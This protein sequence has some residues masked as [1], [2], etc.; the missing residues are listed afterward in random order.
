MNIVS[1]D[2]KK[3]KR[4]ALHIVLLGLKNNV[5][6]A[7]RSVLAKELDTSRGQL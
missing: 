5:L 6:N 7:L 3:Q 4:V 2:E 1:A